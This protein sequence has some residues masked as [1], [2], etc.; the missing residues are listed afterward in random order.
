MRAESGVF[1]RDRGALDLTGTVRFLQDGGF[2]ISTDRASIDFRG[3]E[4]E[5]NEPVSMNGPSGT[6]HAEG[7][8]IFDHG[9]RVL[10]TGKA[11]MQFT[12]KTREDGT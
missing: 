4:A 2:E 12:Q 6:A 7:F 1:N 5:G 8:K 10:L 11:S 9:R 3:G